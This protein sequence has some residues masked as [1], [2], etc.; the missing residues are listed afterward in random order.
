MASTALKTLDR[1]S[2]LRVSALSGG[3]MLVALY[4]DLPGFAQGPGTPPPPLAP[5]A[6]VRIDANG[7]VTITAKNPEVGQGVKTMLPMLIAEELDVDWSAVRIEQADARPGEVRRA[8]RRRQHGDAEQLDADATGWRSRAS[9]AHRGGRLGLERSGGRVHDVV[10]EGT[11]RGLQPIRWLR[12][13]CHE[14]RGPDAARLLDADAQNEEGLQDH[15][16]VDA[17]RGQ[18]ADRHGQ[19]DLRYRLHAAR[20]VARRVREVSRSSAVRS[21]ARIS[22]PSRPCLASATRL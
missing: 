15:R 14:G 1:R 19:A 11:A 22:T 8:G 10:G 3:G 7:I 6:F 9:H 16:Q 13:G 18:S 17:G 2:F 12:R 20:D 4:V 21:S 5:N